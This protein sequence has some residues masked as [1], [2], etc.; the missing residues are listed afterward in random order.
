MKPFL[1]E[2]FLLDS[3]TAVDLY[4]GVAA[5][6]PILDYHCHLSPQQVADNHRFRSLTEIWL[7]GDHYKWRAM[8]ADGV[9]ER[10]ITGA[11]TDWE[12]F[13]AWA[14]T[15]P[16]TLRNPLYHWTHLELRFPFGLPGKLLGPQTAR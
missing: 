4:H 1:D 5:P 2:N 9:P 11:A 3:P 12:K 13:E 10:A 15:V 14:K 7:D 6:Q 8:R 16:H